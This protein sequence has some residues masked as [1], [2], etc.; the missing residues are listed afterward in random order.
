MIVAL[1]YLGYSNNL[2][3]ATAQNRGFFLIS[4][5]LKSF[6]IC[7]VN[8][9]VIITSY[10]S[11]NSNRTLVKD[12]LSRSLNV[13]VQTALVT[14]PLAVIILLTGLVDFNFSAIRCFLPF[15]A[16]AYWFV[17]TFIC[18]SMILPLLNRIR[19]FIDVRTL[20]YLTLSLIVIYSVFGTLFEI[21]TWKEVQHG[22]TLIW[23]VTLYFCT[24]WILKFEFHKR[25]PTWFS[26]CSYL[27]CS[28]VIFSSV[29]LIEALGG[30]FSGKENYI[31]QN[32][33]SL[34][35][36]LQ[37]FALFLCFIKIKVEGK[38]KNVFSFLAQGSLMSYIL[39]MHPLIKEIYE[40]ISIEQ[41]Y[42][43]SIFFYIVF[44]FVTAISVFLIAVILYHLLKKIINKLSGVL[45]HL[46][47]RFIHSKKL[48]NIKDKWINAN[49]DKN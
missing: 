13:W 1:H 19:L 3:I 29:V 47:E 41:F 40:N 24:A 38:S 2:M 37:S 33:A 45:L 26:G 46:I 16:K 17:T 28:L 18:F 12:G 20:T 23:F 34:P 49:Y 7:G 42:P 39:H 11:I 21:F 36:F 25:I 14:I 30:V 35:I 43:K 4:N 15:T 32:Y 10:I 44:C 48:N 6:C 5:L 22:Y 8:V 9:F 31:I 27:F